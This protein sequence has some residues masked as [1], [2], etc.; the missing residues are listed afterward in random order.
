MSRWISL[1]ATS[2]SGKT[3][4]VCRMCGRTSPVPDKECREVP[5]TAHGISASCAVLEEAHRAFELMESG[6][7]KL[8][9]T[10]LSADIVALYWEEDDGARRRVWLRTYAND[11]IEEALKRVAEKVDDIGLTTEQRT[12]LLA[13]PTGSA[14]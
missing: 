11:A 14:G 10:V 8:T 4:F 3:L 9:Y 1:I 7:R 13:E 5:Y 12:K 6:A 2:P